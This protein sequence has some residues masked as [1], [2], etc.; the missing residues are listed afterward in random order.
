MTN[1]YT[2][3]VTFHKTELPFRLI[4]FPR[5]GWCSAR[6]HIKDIRRENF[7]ELL[8][9][10]GYNRET[11][12]SMLKFKTVAM[13]ARILSTTAKS[14]KPIGDRLARKCE[15]AFNKPEGWMDSINVSEDALRLAKRFDALPADRRIK[16]QQIVDLAEPPSTAPVAMLPPPPPALP[17]PRK[18][19]T[20]R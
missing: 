12:A 7:R 10:V 18:R 2:K 17:A 5:P 13:I 14:K 11:M 20:R 3:T 4:P 1:L 16:V 6:M 19:R 15:Q 9:Q 8:A